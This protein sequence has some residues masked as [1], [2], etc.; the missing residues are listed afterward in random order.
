[1]YKMC[2]CRGETAGAISCHGTNSCVYRLIHERQ[3]AVLPITVV[4]GQVVKTDA[5]PSLAELRGALE[6]A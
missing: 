1:M 3:L 4:H 6:G 2:I 5:Y